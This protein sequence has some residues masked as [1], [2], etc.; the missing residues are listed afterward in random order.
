MYS[1]HILDRIFCEPLV[2]VLSHLNSV[3]MD[4]AGLELYQYPAYVGCEQK[5]VPLN[6]WRGWWRK[7]Y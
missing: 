2:S 7:C 4:F 5:A 6:H 1:Y 3:A